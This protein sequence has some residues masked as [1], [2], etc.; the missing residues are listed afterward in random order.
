[1]GNRDPATCTPKA[2][3]KGSHWQEAG[4][5]NRAGLMRS[6]YRSSMKCVVVSYISLF[7]HRKCINLLGATHFE[8][9]VCWLPQFIVWKGILILFLVI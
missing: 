7:P 6:C 4:I 2:A 3:L 9:Y 1:M 8:G 5:Q